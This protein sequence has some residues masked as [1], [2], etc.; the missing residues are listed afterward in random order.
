MTL[1]AIDC[2]NSRLK[3]GVCQRDPMQGVSWLAQGTLPY[4]DLA[5]F[6]EI[7]QAHPPIERA[8]RAVVT[9]VAGGLVADVI[10]ATLAAMNLPVIWARGQAEQCGVRNLYEQPERLGADRWAAL[11]GA[12]HLHGGP[13]LVVCAGTA[14]TADVLDADGNFQG[15]L[16]LPGVDLMLRALAQNTA[17]LPL[18]DGHFTGL[19]RN[20]ADAI[21]SGCIHAQLGAI[22]RIYAQVA[23]LPDAVCLVTGGGA[24]PF[25]DLLRVPKRR[26]DNLVLEGLAH[27]GNA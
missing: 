21:A 3:W 14:T 5:G 18:S 15:G 11:I 19:P 17:Q 27:I 26:I 6:G 7:L 8:E 4:A 25:F 10:A 16:I 13:C 24:S 12:R 22:E 20:T 2:G 1:L 9:N 23:A